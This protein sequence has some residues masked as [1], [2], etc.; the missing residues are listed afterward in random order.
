MT[1]TINRLSRFLLGVPVVLMGTLL[2]IPTDASRL[3]LS[4][5]IDPVLWVSYNGGTGMAS[6]L[7]VDYTNSNFFPGAAVDVT[8]NDGIGVSGV[9]KDGGY[10]IYGKAPKS[11]Y[12]VFSDGKFAATGTKSAVVPTSY[13]PVE[14]YTEEAADVWFTDYGEARLDK[15]RAHVDIDP[16]FLETVTIDGKHPVK[17]FVQLMGEANGVYV[18]RGT[19]GFE[20]IELNNGQSRAEFT[21]RIV[22][23]R[24]GYET[25]RLAKANVQMIS[26]RSR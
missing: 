26:S 2:T 15:G 5:T 10:G 6:A 21:Y 9:C 14:L 3:T 7:L 16:A 17:V 19:T 25:L 22:A 13:G 1:R 8:A 24:K 18:Q 11:G 4:D 23:K 20:V 12:S